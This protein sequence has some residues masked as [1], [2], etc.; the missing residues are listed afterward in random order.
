MKKQINIQKFDD[1]AIYETAVIVIV[2]A[3][4]EDATENLKECPHCH[5]TRI[6]KLQR[7]TGYLVGTT[8]R[9]PRT[10]FCSNR[11]RLL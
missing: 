9:G 6:D 11:L 7:I 5:S 10:Q 1:M 8:D 2:D 4:Y 3:G